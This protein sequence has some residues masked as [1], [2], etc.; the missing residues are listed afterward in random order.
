MIELCQI[1]KPKNSV[2]LIP[3]LEAGIINYDETENTNMS[4]FIVLTHALVKPHYVVIT[5]EYLTADSNEKFFLVYFITHSSEERDNVKIKAD[6]V[7]KEFLLHENSHITKSKFII[8]EKDIKPN[9]I[10]GYFDLLSY[11]KELKGLV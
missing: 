7:T 3:F 8:F 2:K 6:W 9:K 11:E 10:F 1:R 4:A 5:S